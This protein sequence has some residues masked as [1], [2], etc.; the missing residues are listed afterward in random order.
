MIFSTVILAIIVVSLLWFLIL[1]KLNHPGFSYFIVIAV[2]VALLYH[3]SVHS[4]YIGI[5]VMG[6]GCLVVWAKHQS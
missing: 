3:G 6:L 5:E 1:Q 4:I 2:G